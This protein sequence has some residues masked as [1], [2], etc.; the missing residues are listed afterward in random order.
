MYIKE[1]TANHP[2]HTVLDCLNNIQGCTC[3][4]AK[5][6][7]IGGIKSLGT[8]KLFVFDKWL[9]RAPEMFAN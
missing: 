5:N 9:E 7:Q 2:S 6:S 1:T 3:V 4:L 8:K